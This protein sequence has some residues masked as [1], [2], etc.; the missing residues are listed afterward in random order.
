MVDPR[1]RASS[2]KELAMETSKKKRTTQPLMYSTSDDGTRWLY[3]VLHGDGWEITRNGERV[4][5]GPGGTKS[6]QAG[7]DRFMMLTSSQSDAE[8]DSLCGQQ[9]VMA[10]SA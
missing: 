6:I 2:A 9:T 8:I 3:T 7:V 10:E 1:E 4:A 5:R